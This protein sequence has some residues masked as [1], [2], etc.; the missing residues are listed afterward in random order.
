[1][2]RVP[3]RFL[4]ERDFLAATPAQ[5]YGTL[6]N[7][8]NDAD[9]AALLQ[10]ALAARI[11]RRTPIA[12][13]YEPLLHVDRDS[14]AQTSYVEVNRYLVDTL[15]RDADAMSMH[16][17]LEV[18]PVLLDHVLAEFA[19]ALPSSLKLSDSTNKPLLNKPLLVEAVRDLLPPEL[20]NREKL[21]FELPLRAWLA[22]PLRDRARD[23]L[24]SLEARSIFADDY[25][26]TTLDDIESGRQPA[27]RTWA[28]VMLIE[29][30]RRWQVQ[31]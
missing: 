28:Y 12:D 1:L 22:G 23:A 13:L 16:W 15:L 29:W 20:L 3:G 18:R 10:P 14:I 4:R 30:M 19:F 2:R 5:R 27:L 26:R 8:S 21:G 9:K 25:L 7:F 31:V 17:S 6:R 24:S 11:T